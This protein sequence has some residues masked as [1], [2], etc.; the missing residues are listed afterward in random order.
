MN[1][2][3]AD[4]R[5]K[6]LRSENEPVHEIFE[7]GGYIAKISDMGLGKQLV[8]QSSYG[9]SLI[10]ES[11]LGP[12]SNGAQSSA[13]GAVPGS[14]G[15][16]A[17]EVMAMRLQSDCS[18]RSDGSGNLVRSDGS[19]SAVEPSADVSSS[20]IDLVAN[21]RTSR[22]TDIFSLGCIFFSTLVPG[23]HP[24]G[25]W[26]ER[27]ANIVH[28]RPNLDALEALSLDAY[29]LVSSMIQRNQN[30]RPTAKQICD[31]PF[32]WPADRRLAFLCDFSDRLETGAGANANGESNTAFASRALAVERNAAKVVG[33][34]WDSVLDDDLISN[35]QRFRTYDPSS[36]RDLLR[37]IRNKHHHFDELPDHVKTQMGCNSEGLMN[38]FD[39]KFPRLLIHCVTI[40][41]EIL[42]L[43]D[44]LC[45]KYAISPI[46]R[47]ST[48][49]LEIQVSTISELSASVETESVGLRSDASPMQDDEDKATG[50]R[51]S[52]PT[53][54][55]E[56]EDEPDL[57]TIPETN[58][59]VHAER[60]GSLGNGEEESKLNEIAPDA[61]PEPGERSSRTEQV[62]SGATPAEVGAGLVTNVTEASVPIPHQPA[63]PEIADVSDLVIWECSTAAK[64]FNSRGWS[65]SDEEWER[66]VDANLRKRDSALVRCA[67]DPRFR[68]RLCNHWD[69]SMG[70]FCPMLK[71]KK[72]I[73][74]HGPVELRVK[75]A[76]RHRWGKL[77]DRNGDNNNPNHSGGEDTYGAARSIESERKQEGKWS[78]DKK[79]KNKKPTATKKTLKPNN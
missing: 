25:E 49:R 39:A 77:V 66:R 12:H 63:L 7:R 31:H 10:G 65:R 44:P 20:P 45:I 2:L 46:G 32:F 18:V 47:P 30:V 24:F 19:I 9:A 29:D 3:L 11:S 23:S 79:T 48:R 34:A 70:T 52:T 50:S 61:A 33:L 16:Q 22:S 15:W 60:V 8:G 75:E 5:K 43:D 54:A 6:S 58:E 26:Y 14:V 55:A 13:A 78:T 68:T 51:T 76:K 67:E 38:Y 53:P 59:L 42:P 62:E 37:L 35:V 27:E 69:E 57:E 71:K 56:T 17:P 64:T 1:I 21:S 40:C 74:A 36:V 41:R 4:K 73:F 72:C 28:N